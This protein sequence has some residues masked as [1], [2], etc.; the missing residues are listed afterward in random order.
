VAGEVLDTVTGQ[1]EGRAALC[2]GV[3]LVPRFQIVDKSGPKR[4]RATLRRWL[5][6]AYFSFQS[7]RHSKPVQHH[8]DCDN[9]DTREDRNVA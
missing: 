4:F 7:H 5:C 8:N 9:E 2:G 3:L 1:G 6:P